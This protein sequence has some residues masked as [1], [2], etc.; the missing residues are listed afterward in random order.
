MGPGNP[1]LSSFQQLGLSSMAIFWVIVLGISAL[2]F[3]FSLTG[4]WIFN[5]R[6]GKSPYLGGILL[7]GY[8]ISFPAIEKMHQF[9]LKYHNADNPIFDLNKATVCKTTGRIFPD[10][11]GFS[12]AKTTAWSFINKAHSGNYVSWGSLTNTE[13][14]KFLNLLP[15][16]IKDFQIEQSSE[17]SNPE[18]ASEFH[19]ALKPGP[20]YVDLEQGVLVGWKCVPETVLEV[21]IVQQTKNLKVNK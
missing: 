1:D 14:N 12:G 9:F 10:T 15:D 2:I 11:L 5:G 21:L 17:E 19:Q 6:I 7:N 13:K 4:W 3:L 20:L 18:K 16:S 8:E